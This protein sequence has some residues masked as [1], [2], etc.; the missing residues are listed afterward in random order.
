MVFFVIT[1]VADDIVIVTV[2]VSVI[3]IIVIVTVIVTVIISP[4]RRR[5]RFSLSPRH[6]L[7]L[8][9]FDFVVV[10]SFRVVSVADI[11]VMQ[12]YIVVVIGIDIVSV[13]IVCRYRRHMLSI[14]LCRY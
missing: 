2:I 5:Y 14:T 4:Y 8:S 10:F 12:R 3:V 6:R 1:V 9:S 11:V 13:F 7:S